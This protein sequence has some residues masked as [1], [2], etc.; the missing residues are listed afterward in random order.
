MNSDWDKFKYY[1]NQAN[2]LNKRL[3][4]EH[5]QEEFIQCGNDVNKNWK[6]N[7]N[8][9]P[10]KCKDTDPKLVVNDDIITDSLQIVNALNEAFN[11]VSERLGNNTQARSLDVNSLKTLS[12]TDKEFKFKEI[13]VQ[14]VKN[15]ILNI[16]CKKAVGIDG[17]HSKLLKLA[18]EYISEPI[19][20]LFNC[21]LETS[22]IPMDFKMARITPIHKGG[23][24]EINNFQPISVL[25]V[26]S[27]ILEKAVHKQLYTYLNENNML[28]SQQSGFR[29]SHSTATCITDIVD[30]LLEN[31]NTKQ[32]TGSIFLD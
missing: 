9:L 29:P 17:L 27:K 6:I 12:N 1:R 8:L 16:N 24:Y 28:S 19:T 14:F 15:E 30:Y 10:K 23:T 21:S 20:F 11:N 25:P 31:M 22:H 13:T 26:L 4:K 5:Y 2:N 18:A 3:K 32:L 7:K